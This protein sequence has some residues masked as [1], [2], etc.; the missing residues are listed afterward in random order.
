MHETNGN[1][2]KLILPSK[3]AKLMLHTCI[4]FIVYCC[5]HGQLFKGKHR[6]LT[7]CLYDTT[8]RCINSVVKALANNLR[9][10]GSS[11]TGSGKLPSR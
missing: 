2:L 3:S 11:H 1:T 7:L 4:T 9:I 5:T 10:R 6:I 8:R